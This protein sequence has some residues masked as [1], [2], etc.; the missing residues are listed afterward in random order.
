MILRDFMEAYELAGEIGG[1]LRADELDFGWVHRLVGESEEC[2]LY[3]LKEECHALFRFDEESSESELQTEELF[4]LAVGALFHEAMKF[5][6]GYY[7]TTSYAPRLERMME[8]GSA[9]GPLAGSFLQVI[10]AGRQRMLESEVEMAEL[11]DETRDQLAVL[12]RHLP[13]SGPIARSL[14]EEPERSEKV[15][16]VPLPELLES[17]YPS[18]SEAYVLAVGDLLE[19][20]HFAEARALL[21]RDDVRAA[22]P[23]GPEADCFSRSMARFVAGAPEEAL[24]GL[25]RW[26]EAGA[27]GPE[28]WRGQAVRVLDSLIEAGAE[29]SLVEGA[30]KLREELVQLSPA[31]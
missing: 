28:L 19:N 23:F 22:N 29:T 10:E 8:Q 14:I 21:E 24:E 31:P 3:R 7:L 6:E 13:H 4:D 15:F 25:R 2:A 27:P 18:R 9:K 12:L 30:R 20:G 17:I 16:G 1:H 26:V 5:R 11:F